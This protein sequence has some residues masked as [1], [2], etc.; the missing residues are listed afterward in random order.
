MHVYTCTTS[1][2]DD[3]RGSSG[4]LE[5]LELEVHMDESLYVDAGSCPESSGGR[6]A[7]CVFNSEPF[8][9]APLSCFCSFVSGNLLFFFFENFLIK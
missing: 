2:P 9:Q 5:S 1:L 4:V 6:G 3:L 7:V 8:L